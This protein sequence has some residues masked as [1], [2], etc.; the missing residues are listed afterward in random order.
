MPAL[1]V[2]GRRSVPVF[3][4]Q[5][6]FDSGGLD[7]WSTAPTLTMPPQRH[8]ASSEPVP[9]IK[10]ALPALS[11]AACN[12]TSG[13]SD[14][15]APSKYPATTP[16]PVDFEQSQTQVSKGTTMRQQLLHQI[17]E[18]ERQE[19]ET[20][21][22]TKQHEVRYD[23]RDF[24]IDYIVAKFRDSFF[25][26]PPY[27][28]EF[29]WTVA[30]K[31]RFVESII[32]GLPIPMMFVADMEDGRLEIVDGAQRIQ[33][34]EEF[35]NS[36][37]QLEGLLRLPSLNGFK[38]SDLPLA[39]QRKLGTKAL[40]VVVLEDSTSAELRQEV[41]DRVNTSGMRARASEI[42]RGALTGPFMDFVKE[43]AHDKR[44]MS[45]CPISGRTRMRREDE[46]LV[47]RFL[48]YSERYKDFRHDVDLFLDR[49]ARDHRTDFNGE[50]FRREFTRTM[51]FVERHFPNGFAKTSDAQSTPR[52]RFEA[53]AV[54]TNLALR[55]KPDLCPTNV[56]AWLRST[57]F[58]VHTTTH[59]SNSGPRLR[60]RIE[61]VRDQLLGTAS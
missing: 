30:N 23:L 59:A 49:F 20:E 47:L 33:T 6:G 37:L 41:F 40:R 22:R 15:G 21:I 5:L 3:P 31:C 25:Y 28:R 42:R 34:L 57:E 53:I 12:E 56:V 36:D 24:T 2:C 32:L 43:L 35:T 11:V 17:G 7:A 26:V 39:Q 54:G 38:F 61:Y 16:R 58:E 1:Y 46:E 14:V 45:L 29:I 10:R 19:A 8:L 50:R 48:A 9:L 4:L 13:K 27:Q 60:G 52:V 51:E 44:F 18:A 55:S